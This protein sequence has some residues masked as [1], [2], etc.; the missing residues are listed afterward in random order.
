MFI[1][2]LQHS[3]S[4]YFAKYLFST[5]HVSYNLRCF[6]KIHSQPV[7]IVHNVHAVAFCN[8]SYFDSYI[9]ATVTEITTFIHRIL[10]MEV[11]QFLSYLCYCCLK[12]KIEYVDLCVCVSVCD[13]VYVCLCQ[14]VCDC[15]CVCQCVCECVCMCVCLCQCACECV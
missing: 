13:C 14:C 12:Y 8:Q 15:V 6:T 1:W 2:Q 11:G 9:I 10:V 7:H 5:L 4:G 3:K